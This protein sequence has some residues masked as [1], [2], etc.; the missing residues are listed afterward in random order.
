[1]IDTFSKP[2]LRADLRQI[3][4]QR[5]V[6]PG[7]LVH[8]LVDGY[9]H[10][11]SLRP[12]QDSLLPL[13]F[14]YKRRRAGALGGFYNKV[15]YGR[16][17]RATRAVSLLAGRMPAFSVDSASFGVVNVESGAGDVA[18]GLINKDATKKGVSF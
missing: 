10:T 2:V 15:L 14:H 5:G 6:L 7:H 8:V 18:E 9:W 17:S 3:A 1:M 13:Q 4:A 12:L 11:E 16:D